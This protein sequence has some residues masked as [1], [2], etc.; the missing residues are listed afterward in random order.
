MIRH[1]VGDMHDV[2]YYST[3]VLVGAIDAY[4]GVIWVDVASTSILYAIAIGFL[5][6]VN[7]V[8]GAS[9]ARTFIENKVEMRL[10]SKYGALL[11]HYMESLDGDER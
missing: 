4:L 5:F 7:T 6:G 10:D 9:I 1:G 11:Q 8:I 3:L 2:G